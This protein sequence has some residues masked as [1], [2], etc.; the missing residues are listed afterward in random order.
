MRVAPEDKVGRVSS[1]VRLIALIGLVP[2]TLIGGSIA[3]V[4]G[5]RDAMLVSAVGWTIAALY[6]AA[7]PALRREAR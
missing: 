1:A 2:G 5:A 7:I 4:Y 6:A 3:Q